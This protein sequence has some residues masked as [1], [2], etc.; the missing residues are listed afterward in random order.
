MSSA[1]EPS[2]SSSSSASLL[3]LRRSPLD[4]SLDTRINNM[5]FNGS[6]GVLEEGECSRSANPTV[7]EHD[8]LSDQNF[9]DSIMNS[10]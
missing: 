5:T 8:N 6:E 10:P 1:E 4:Q 2:T 7:M 3:G 9:E